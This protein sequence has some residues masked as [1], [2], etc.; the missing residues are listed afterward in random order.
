MTAGR[1]MRARQAVRSGG[2]GRPVRQK[3]LPAMALGGADRAARPLLRL[4]LPGGPAAG[5][6]T[7]GGSG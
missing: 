2:A 3:E 5:R 6:Q 7:G 4:P 1:I